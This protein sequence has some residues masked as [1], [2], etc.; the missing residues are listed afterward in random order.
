MQINRKLMLLL[1]MFTAAIIADD[2][3]DKNPVFRM[4]G[5]DLGRNMIANATNAPLSW[6]PETGENILWTAQLG[7][8]T[9]TNALPYDGKIFIATNNEA[10]RNPKLKGDRGVIMAFDQQTGKFLWQSTH[11]KLPS[12]M[13]N[14]WPLQGI[15]STP[16]VE[17]KRLWYVSNRCEIVCV[18][19]EGFLDGENDGPYQD[20]ENTSEIDADIIWKLDMID[21]LDVF[22]HNLAAGSPLIVGDIL[23]T[24]TGNGVDE[25]HI[26]L[27]SP[28]APSFLAVNKNTGEVIWEDNSPGEQILHGTWSNPSYGVV[29]GQPQVVF[30][31][32]D[33]WL[34]SFVPETGELIWKFNCNPAEAVWELGGAGTKNNIISTPVI[35]DN[36]VYLGVGQDPE[37]GEAPGHFWVIDA[38]QKGDITETAVIWHRSGE[39][40]HRTMSTAAIENGLLFITDLSGFLYCLDA[41]TGQHYWTY[42][43]FAAVW[44]SPV[45]ADGKVYIGDEDGDIAVLKAAKTKEL[46]T[47]I[48]MGSAVYS[49]PTFHNGVMYIASR[50]T[51]FAIG[52]Q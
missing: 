2:K 34:Y 13:V 20:E 40:F 17:G 35:Y 19:T 50:T 22:P 45:I 29:N 16:F 11:E 8:Q 26:L 10:E 24:V 48:N 15:C 46:I 38:T 30:A 9:Y 18:D 51:L 32:G 42:D 12:G 21:E 4:Y 1:M 39:D 43:V 25:S 3:G 36:R 7:S 28:A 52:Q 6:D 41:A 49:T 33:G 23:F 27:P 47:E 14:D 31:G 37:H 5:G 44:G